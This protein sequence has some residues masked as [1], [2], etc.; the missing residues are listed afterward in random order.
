MLTS[1]TLP[2]V[3]CAPVKSGSSSRPHWWEPPRKE[4]IQLAA[5]MSACLKHHQAITG[6][7]NPAIQSSRNPKAVQKRTKQTGSKQETLN[8]GLGRRQKKWERRRRNWEFTEE[9]PYRAPDNERGPGI[10]VE[11]I[12]RNLHPGIAGTHHENIA[13]LVVCAGLVLAGM[14]HGT[15]EIGGA[16]DH[17]TDGLRILTGCYHK[18]ASAEFRRHGS[19]LLQHQTTA[20]TTTQQ[21]VVRVA[22]R[23]FPVSSRGVERGRRDLLV[24]SEIQLE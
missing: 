23:D 20:T 4:K 10:E 18:P 12:E 21:R 16:G 6:S 17:G 19:S 9:L 14:Q 1:Q 7:C 2:L 3:K 11:E 22:R 8:T 5:W 15:F 24:E 13:A